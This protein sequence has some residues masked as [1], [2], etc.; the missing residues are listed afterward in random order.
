M[1]FSGVWC[2]ALL[3]LCGAGCHATRAQPLAPELAGSDEDAQLEFWHALPERKAVSNDEAFHALLLFVDG[4]DDSADYDGRVSAMKERRML[5]AGFREGAGEAARRGTV[6]RALSR[7]LGVEGGLTMRVFG[8]TSRYA[9][10]ELQYA[11]VFP[12]SSPQQ[13]FSGAEF[14]GIMGRAEDYQRVQTD[15]AFAPDAAGEAVGGGG[16]DDGGA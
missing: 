6:A 8:P 3:A 7:A 12:P 14:L 16:G 10:R 9:T 13:T 4:K 2:V 11:G 15:D 5:P 1:R